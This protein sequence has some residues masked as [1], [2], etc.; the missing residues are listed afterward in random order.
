MN[1]NGP[2]NRL[3]TCSPHLHPIVTWIGSSN[4]LTKAGLKDGQN[5]IDTCVFLQWDLW[6]IPL[7]AQNLFPC[8]W[9]SSWG[10]QSSELHTQ[11]CFNAPSQSNLLMQS[12]RKGIRLHFP[13]LW[14]ECGFE[15]STSESQGRLVHWNTLK[16]GYW[17]VSV[18]FVTN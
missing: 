7:G 17:K 12:T 11:K 5:M 9:T 10:D 8:F 15:S 18:L 13:N 6:C 4:L 3:V 2:C 1:M 16:A 14:P